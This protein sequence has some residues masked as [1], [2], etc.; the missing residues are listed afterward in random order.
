MPTV[1][2]S[3]K[4]WVVIPR[5]IRERYNIRPGDKV[6]IVDYA[7]RIAIIPAMK[8]PIREAR[9]MFKGGRSLTGLL[10]EERRHERLREERDVERWDSSKRT[11]GP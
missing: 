5:E 3:T 10:L 2:V 8:D 7:G 1:T 6:H 11:S 9:G 4:G